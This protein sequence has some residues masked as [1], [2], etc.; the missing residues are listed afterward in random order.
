MTEAPAPRAGSAARRWAA[1]AATMAIMAACCAHSVHAAAVPGRPPDLVGTVA[2]EP[3]A[4]YLVDTSP[5][6]DFGPDYFEG[7]SIVTEPARGETVVVGSDDRALPSPGL[8]AGDVVE[9]WI[10]DVCAESSPVQCD[11]V[12]IRVTAQAG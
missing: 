5:T 2:G 3:G 10:G 11:V 1:A 8:E 12:A 4:A 9:V 6:T 7:M